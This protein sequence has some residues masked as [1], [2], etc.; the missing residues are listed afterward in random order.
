MSARLL[1]ALGVRVRRCADLGE[2]KLWI[3]DRRLALFDFELSE[4]EVA[5]R[6][7]QHGSREGPKAR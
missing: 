3:P 5:G 4:E 7:S 2:G 1:D 6:H